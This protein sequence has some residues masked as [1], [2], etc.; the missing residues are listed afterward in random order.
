MKKLPVLSASQVS[1]YELCARK[2]AWQ[3]IDGLPSPPNKYAEMGTRVHAALEQ[4]LGTCELPSDDTLPGVV[5]RAMIPH[6]PPPQAVQAENIEREFAWSRD[7]VSFRGFMDLLVPSSTGCTIYDHKTTSDLAWAKTPDDLLEDVQATLYACVA[8][9]ELQIDAVDL[10][11]TYATR[12]PR[13]SVQPTK[14][15]VLREDIE[16]RVSRTVQS[17]QEMLLIHAAGCSASEVPYDASACQAFGGC[18]FQENCNLT[19][20]QRI[21]SV[22]SQETSKSSFLQRLQARKAASA[23]S[24]VAVN[25]PEAETPAPAPT[26]VAVAVKEVAEAV[27]DVIQELTPPDQP[28]PPRKRGPGRPRKVAVVEA[29][30]AAPVAA[31]K[32]VVAPVA[33]PKPVAAP[34]AAP[35]TGWTL[36]LDC[37]PVKGG[38]AEHVSDRLARVMLAFT[39]ETG[40]G[41]YKLTDYGKGPALFAEGF[42][43]D[44]AEHPPVGGIVANTA[45]QEVRDVLQALMASAARIIQG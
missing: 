16:P 14:L 43:R 35:A 41:H 36:Y 1:T 9:D 44:L 17:A 31:P 25:P 2:W 19:P 34:V 5:A 38:N 20:Q 13:P 29:P 30:V 22:M 42:A 7:G 11:W 24:A 21:Q 27:A 10:Q 39:A 45:N 12:K 23:T 6:L 4:W 40:L 3:K 33:A 32:P 15:R 37:Q 8:M 26:P 18:P 28:E